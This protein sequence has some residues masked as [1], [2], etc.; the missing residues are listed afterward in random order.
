VSGSQRHYVFE[1]QQ[2]GIGWKEDEKKSTD[3]ARQ[4]LEPHDPGGVDESKPR[5]LTLRDQVSPR[6][7]EKERDEFPRT[8]YSREKRRTMD[9]CEKEGLGGNLGPGQKGG[10]TGRKQLRAGGLI[11][12]PGL[13]SPEADHHSGCPS[14]C[15]HNG[16][17]LTKNT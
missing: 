4:G 6:N 5:A 12:L 2:G 10:G 17:L 13:R 11:K 14:L 9:R 3:N 16:P 7:Q 8:C 1:T 15:K